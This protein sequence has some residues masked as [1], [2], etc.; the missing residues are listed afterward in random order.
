MAECNPFKRQHCAALTEFNVP[1]SRVRCAHESR[2][3]AVHRGAG[4]LTW[5]ARTRPTHPWEHPTH[6]GDLGRDRA[7]WPHRSRH[8]Q[9]YLR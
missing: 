8:F 2:Q 7:P 6:P 5:K 1:F 9:W 4:L 3:A